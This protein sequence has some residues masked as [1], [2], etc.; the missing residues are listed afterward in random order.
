MLMAL[1]DLGKPPVWVQALAPQRREEEEGKKGVVR[2]RF[3]HCSHGHGRA[4]EAG[5]RRAIRPRGA[6]AS[7]QTR[8]AIN[9]GP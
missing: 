8:H 1:A 7:R 9:R 5:H 3:F 4:N 6:R 2:L